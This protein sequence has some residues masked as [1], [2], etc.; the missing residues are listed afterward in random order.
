MKI[1]VSKTKQNLMRQMSINDS[2]YKI[3]NISREF[4][5]LFLGMPVQK[6]SQQ[7]GFDG[8]ITELNQLLHERQLVCRRYKHKYSHLWIGMLLHTIPAKTQNTEDSHLH[9]FELH[10]PSSKSTKLRL[11]VIKAIIN[12]S[13]HNGR[14]K[15]G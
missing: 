13:L 11:Q 8:S 9:G 12:Q 6:I 4:R 10:R 2:K 15:M 14:W 3:L 7:T 1:L 5:R